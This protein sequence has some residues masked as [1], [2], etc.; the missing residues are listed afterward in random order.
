MDHIKDLLPFQNE[1][2]LRIGLLGGSFNPAHSG[3][4]HISLEAIRL[5]NLDYVVWLVSPQNPLKKLDISDSLGKRLDYAKMLVRHPKVIVSDLEKY[6]P[7]NYTADTIAIL[8]SLY[9]AVKFVWMMGADNM[10]QIHKWYNWQSIFN[11]VF[12][13]VFDR[14]EYEDSVIA[15]EANKC[16]N[17]LEMRM[18][19]LKNY[20]LE[21]SA[22]YFFKIKKSSMSST[23]L[24]ELSHSD[25]T[26]MI[27]PNNIEQLKDIVLNS[28]DNDQASEITICD[29]KG[30]ANFA[31]YLIIASGR[32]SRHVCAIIENLMDR[33]K[34][35]H[36]ASTASGLENGQWVLLDA[37]DIIINAFL[38]E[39][40][41]LYKLEEIWGT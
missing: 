12:I 8:R 29:L 27:E 5:L 34:K 24:R 7:T 15:C 36:V 19:D 23:H 16:Y 6:L 18:D 21:P 4:I 17:A 30:K 38:P 2:E 22:W 26:I 1:Q 3:H 25:N 20:S 14:E 32:S 35:V 10:L 40:R 11:S 31:K 41:E 37:G 33:L 13:A 39:Y 9:P 28:L